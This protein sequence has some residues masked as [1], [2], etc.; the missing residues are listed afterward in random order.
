MRIS[1]LMPCY[2]E[3]KT[4]ETSLESICAQRF[5]DWEAVI[6]DDGS[7]DQTA[8]VIEAFR[9]R[10]PY[11]DRIRLIRQE[12]R[13][14][15]LALKNA[16]GYASGDFIYILHGDDCFHDENVL[17]R[18]EAFEKEHPGFDAYF[19]PYVTM[20]E[21]GVKLKEVGIRPYLPAERSL[22]LMQLWLGRNLYGDM[23]F[24]RKDCFTKHV[25]ENYLTWNMPF[26]TRLSESDADALRVLHAA[27]LDFPV[28]CYRLHEGNYLTT[29]LG[30]ANV[31]SGELRAFLNLARFQDIPAYSLQ[32][33]LFRTLNKV[34]PKLTYRPLYFRRQQ[35]N[36]AGIL[37]FILNKSAF[38][39]LAEKEPFATVLSFFEARGKDCPETLELPPLSPSFFAPVGAEMRLYNKRIAEG[40]LTEEEMDFL[41][42]LRQGPRSL[43]CR[44]EDVEKA[45]RY[46]K[47]LGLQRYV[48]LESKTRSGN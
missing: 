43:S 5:E 4:I 26:W 7:T 19:A 25:S 45:E 1:I 18:F 16:S 28:F 6:A 17:A 38:P 20:N 22:P 47:Y 35:K 48:S 32:Y 33:L 46:L 41:K 3:E 29:A 21:D 30:G 36:I 27:A 44:P 23:A 40:K 10:S 12:N 11:G 37:A 8:A 13:D 9:A 39:A 2:N 34:L 14:Q 42:L 15:L 24:F 31:L